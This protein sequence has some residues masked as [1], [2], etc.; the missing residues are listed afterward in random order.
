MISYRASIGEDVTEQLEQPLD[1]TFLRA[2]LL[3]ALGRGRPAELER[4][5]S[6]VGPQRDDLVLQ[7]G[8][9]PAKG[10]ASHGESWSFALALRLASYDLLREEGRRAVTATRCWSWTTSSPS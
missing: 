6:L 10:F 7:L 4:G 1:R 5:V 2:R 3:E 9:L 8:A